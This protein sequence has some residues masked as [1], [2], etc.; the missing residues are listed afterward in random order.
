MNRCCAL[1]A[2]ILALGA[3]AWGKRVLRDETGRTV[4]VSDHVERVISLT[5]SIT[6]TIYALG[7]SSQLIAITDYT[8]YP[9]EATKQKPSVGDILNPSLE[10]IARMHPD[11]VIA[12]STLN[13]PETIRGL[14]RAGIPV[15]LIRG[16]GLEGVYRS[17]LDIGRVLGREREAAALQAE[18]KARE[19]KIRAEA[20]TGKH[21]SVFMV[22]QLDPCI[23]PGKGAFITQLLNIAGARSVTADLPQD[24]VRVSLEAIIPRKPDYIVLMKSSPISLKDIQEAPGWY[25]LEAV[26]KGRILRA[27]DRLQLPSPV[28]FDGLEDLAH[29]IQTAH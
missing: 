21:P 15:F 20:E 24:W 2:M 5:P 7:A 11:V 25:A 12:M 4:T 17:I 10:K 6:D 18:L 13:S 1:L 8:E 23:T 28:A 3:S 14:E 27:D 19:Q 16:Q 22:L 26:R 29:R 9:V